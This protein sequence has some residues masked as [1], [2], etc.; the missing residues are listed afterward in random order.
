MTIF[1]L[2]ALKNFNASRNGVLAREASSFD[3][4]RVILQVDY[5]FHGDH[6]N[7]SRVKQ[8]A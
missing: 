7:C 6:L 1:A 4:S 2:Q 5:I 8:T 3:L